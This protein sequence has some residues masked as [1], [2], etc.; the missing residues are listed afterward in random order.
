M[1]AATLLA[2]FVVFCLAELVALRW[3]DPPTTMVQTQ[4]RIEAWVHHRPYRKRQ[5]WVPLSGIAPGL[6]HAVI[7]AEDGRFFQQSTDAHGHSFCQVKNAFAH[8][9]FA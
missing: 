5:Q 1:F 4:R 6:Q 9:G 7:S 2:A 8:P 3:V